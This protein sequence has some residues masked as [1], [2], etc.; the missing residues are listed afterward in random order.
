MYVLL[1]EI[2][3]MEIWLNK[4]VFIWVLLG[5]QETQIQET[6]ETQI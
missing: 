6:Q 2:L 3:E 4:K 5:L 1:T